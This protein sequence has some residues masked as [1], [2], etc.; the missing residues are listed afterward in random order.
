MYYAFGLIWLNVGLLNAGLPAQLADA[1]NALAD[2]RVAGVQAT[3][4]GRDCH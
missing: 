2:K 3:S 1:G 4:A